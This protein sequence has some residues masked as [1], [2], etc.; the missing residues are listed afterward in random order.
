MKQEVNLFFSNS[1]YLDYL[2]LRQLRHINLC[3]ELRW[4]SENQEYMREYETLS[5]FL[6]DLISE[7]AQTIPPAKYHEN[8]DVLAE[9]VIKNLNWK[10]QKVGNRW[11]GQDYQSILEQGG[12]DDFN[13][14]N[15]VKAATGRIKAA[16]ERGQNHFDD[17]E[18]SHR[19]ILAGVLA[20]IVYHRC[21]R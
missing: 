15:L 9:Y 13:E 11:I 10:I 14:D 17:M 19:K 3:W 21:T 2:V 5:G 16:I 20:I 8:E 12:F 1:E 4:D 18:K 7:I 6:I